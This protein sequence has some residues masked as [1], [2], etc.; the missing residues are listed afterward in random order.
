MRKMSKIINFFFL[1]TICSAV[2]LFANDYPSK[3]INLIVGFSPG[4]GTD[5]SARALEP[6]IEKY[7]GGTVAV[8]N[9]PGGSGEVGFTTLAKSKPD[10]Y[11]IGV[12]NLPLFFVN[13]LTRETAY[14]LEDFEVLA[15]MGGSEHTIGVSAESEIQNWAEFQDAA[16]RKSGDFTIGSSGKL[17]DDYLAV[18]VLTKNT[19]VKLTHIPY[20][21]GGPA[22]NAV[23]G[24]HVDSIA[25]NVDESI[26][27]VKGNQIR[28]MGVM[29]EERHPQLPEVPTFKELGYDIVSSSS[30]A[31]MVPKGVDDEILTKLRE[32]V[33]KALNDPEYQKIVK[34][35]GQSFTYINPED[36]LIYLKQEEGRVDELIKMAGVEIN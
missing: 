26:P 1:F 25:F 33:K 31:I 5:T 24:Q 18:L 8:I 28:L 11:T 36:Y 21:G 32:A 13:K 7:I 17:S 2:T 6:F 35:L 14:K 20:K 10:G 9:K 34:K 3:T 29:S 12:I 27:Y 16:M 15:N 4:G 23:M 30:R 22:R 19:G